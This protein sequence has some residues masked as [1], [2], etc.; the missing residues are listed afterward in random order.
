MAA[1]LPERYKNKHGD[2]QEKEMFGTQCHSSQNSQ[3]NKRQDIPVILVQQRLDVYT[4]SERYWLSS[5]ALQ[6]SEQMSGE[7]NKKKNQ[8]SQSRSDSFTRNTK[9]LY[10][11]CEILPSSIVNPSGKKKQQKHPPTLP[12]KNKTKQITKT[13]QCQNKSPFGKKIQ[14]KTGRPEK[15]FTS[16]KL[17]HKVNGKQEACWN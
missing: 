10:C 15:N 9:T 5:K 2:R 12:Q 6:T 4:K 11:E 7:T 8:L 14:I 1:N 17:F 16:E 3:T 13:R